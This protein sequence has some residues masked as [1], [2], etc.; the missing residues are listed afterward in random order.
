MHFIYMM[1]LDIFYL[2]CKFVFINLELSVDVAC[3]LK[4]DNDYCKFGNKEVG[5]ELRL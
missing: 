5:K 3:W 1:H 4:Y 2:S